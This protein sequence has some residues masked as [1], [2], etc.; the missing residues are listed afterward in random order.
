MCFI[1][2]RTEVCTMPYQRSYDFKRIYHPVVTDASVVDL[3][4]TGESAGDDVVVGT[5]DRPQGCGFFH[6]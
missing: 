2:E 3:A 5:V 6:S 1:T 4:V